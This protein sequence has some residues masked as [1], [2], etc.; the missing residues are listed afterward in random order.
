MDMLVQAGHEVELVDLGMDNRAPL[1]EMGPASVNLIAAGIYAWKRFQTWG[2]PKHG[3]NVLWIFDP[4]T[5]NDTSIMHRHKAAAFDAIAAQLDAVLAMNR[6]IA[7]Y[8]ELHH[9][10]LMALKIPYLIADKH[11]ETPADETLRHRPVIFLGGQSAHRLQVES[12]FT[13]HKLATE[14]VWASL[15]GNQR[16][17]WR[18]HCCINL[19]LHAETEH[20]YFDQFRALE[21]WAA[22]AVVLTETTDGL[23][24]FG[25]QPGVH[26][27]MADWHLM[28]QVCSQ[29]LHD[30][31]SREQMTTAAQVILREQ[32]SMSRWRNDILRLLTSL[33]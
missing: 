7:D 14:F 24:E 6:P 31:A 30:R 2:L 4:L 23:A 21:T 12:H 20:T 17:D 10:Q 5:R 9:P 19:S 11:I 15:W 32:F 18:R 25:I 29:L 8:L 3:K 13:A 26:L 22:G 16:D 33:P 28:P 27:A 1:P